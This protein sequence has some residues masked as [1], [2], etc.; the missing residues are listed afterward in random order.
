MK[1]VLLVLSLV[2]LFSCNNITSSSEKITSESLTSV[3]ETTSSEESSISVEKKEEKVLEVDLTNDKEAID[4]STNETEKNRIK[5]LFGE[6]LTDFKS[7][8]AFSSDGGIKLA[9]SKYDGYIE[10]SFTNVISKIEV[11]ARSYTKY[12]DYNQIY[13]CDKPTFLINDINVNINHYENASSEYKLYS[14]DVSELSSNSIKLESKNGRTIL[15]AL[16]IYYFIN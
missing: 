4:L 15:K 8:K 7:E 9:S 10:L 13:H 11:E 5:S 16:K 12:D 14:V 1:K 6:L 2:C 3:I